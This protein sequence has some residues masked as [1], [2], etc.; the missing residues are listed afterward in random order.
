MVKRLREYRVS[1]KY[2]FKH[3]WLHGGYFAD[4]WHQVLGSLSRTEEGEMHGNK[5]KTK[6]F[7]SFF[8]HL[9]MKKENLG[10]E[11]GLERRH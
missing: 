2:H 3:H 9:D 10:K 4:S 6:S 5:N 8:F 11:K 1:N 7:L